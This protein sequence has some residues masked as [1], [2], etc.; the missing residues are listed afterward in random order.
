MQTIIHAGLVNEMITIKV[1]QNAICVVAGK[2][3]ERKVN[4]N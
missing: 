2:M 3:L 4:Q 1:Y